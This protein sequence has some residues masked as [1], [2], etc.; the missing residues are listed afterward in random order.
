MQLLE[1]I[2]DRHYVCGYCGEMLSSNRH[3]QKYHKTCQRQRITRLVLD[4]KVMR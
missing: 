1:L 2:A 3:N 4:K